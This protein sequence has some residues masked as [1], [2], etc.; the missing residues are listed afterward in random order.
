MKKSNYLVHIALK[1]KGTLGL[2]VYGCPQGIYYDTVYNTLKTA[3]PHI[4]KMGK[5]V[6]VASKQ[7]LGYPAYSPGE[8]T[9]MIN[10]IDKKVLSKIYF[11][12]CGNWFDKNSEYILNDH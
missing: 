6:F 8:N 11:E 1:E 3:F 7:E 5:S 4:Y 9:A 10:T 12:E 2:W